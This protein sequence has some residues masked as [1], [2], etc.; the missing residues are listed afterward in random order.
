MLLFLAGPPEIQANLRDKQPWTVNP[1]RSLLGDAQVMAL[2]RILRM[3]YQKSPPIAVY[4]LVGG[5]RGKRITMDDTPAG[6][7][8]K[9][10]DVVWV[11]ADPKAQQPPSSRVAK[12]QQ[13][14]QPKSQPPPQLPPPAVPQSP[15]ITIP[16]R[17]LPP[18]ARPQIPIQY[19]PLPEPL[20][21]VPISLPTSLNLCPPP[22]ILLPAPQIDLQTGGLSG[23]VG[24][25]LMERIVRL[26]G[27]VKDLKRKERS[28]ADSTKMQLMM[29]EMAKLRI[30]VATNTLKQR[31][32]EQRSDNKPI[33]RKSSITSS[34]NMS[35]SASQVCPIHRTRSDASSS[36][37][38]C[39]RKGDWIEVWDATKNATYYANETTRESRWDPRG[40]P[41]EVKP[42]KQPSNSLPLAKSPSQV[43]SQSPV[44][45]GVPATLSVASTS[46]P[47]G[48]QSDM[49]DYASYNEPLPM[50]RVSSQIRTPGPQSEIIPLVPSPSI[51]STA[52]LDQPVPMTR[53][54]S[55]VPMSRTSITTSVP[56]T[57]SSIASVIVAAE[58]YIKPASR[59]S[60]R[61]SIA[62]ESFPVLPVQTPPRE[63]S[64]EPPVFEELKSVGEPKEDTPP[65]KAPPV[66]REYTE[67]VQQKMAP[68]VVVTA[69]RSQSPIR[70]M[71]SASISRASRSPVMAPMGSTVHIPVLQEV[72]IDTYTPRKGYQEGGFRPPVVENEL[73][74]DEDE[75][76][77]DIQS[78]RR[79]ATPPP[80]SPPSGP[81]TEVVKQLTENPHHLPIDVRQKVAQMSFHD[82]WF[83]EL[84]YQ[85]LRSYYYCETRELEQ[86]PT[87]QRDILLGKEQ[88]SSGFS[89]L[90][91]CDTTFGCD[92]PADE[93]DK[94]TTDLLQ[95]LGI[96]PAVLSVSGDYPNHKTGDYPGHKTSDYPG[97]KT[98]DYPGHK[99][100]DYPG[101]KTS[102]YPGHTTVVH[103]QQ[104]TPRIP[105]ERSPSANLSVL[106]SELCRGWNPNDLSEESSNFSDL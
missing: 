41:F 34:A 47:P 12:P 37:E 62:A 52:L 101:Q 43:P 1:K 51:Q 94:A 39:R 71:A 48:D 103:N 69:S 25:K 85:S 57:P 50:S 61:L 8:L 87:R 60:S 78:L 38:V 49:S 77:F 5:K 2:K 10:K 13:L 27:E 24:K 26:S 35:R 64:P 75:E 54:L 72:P 19:P 7:K 102:D 91:W 55:D 4:T 83:H 31:E 67:M 11:E 53:T 97:H 45:D 23:V 21:Q 63:K 28:G 86:S 9:S 100:S 17:D 98:S 33:E 40:T 96:D 46:V 29:E 84:V 14:Q 92:R 36:R 88:N 42:L 66:L 6:L 59:R 90:K 30:E 81:P 99:T 104:P 68:P 74:S 3:D 93:V 80:L 106:T 70:E 22:E 18:P 73:C 95:D 15:S 16:I 20:E 65:Q 105:T 56:P 79:L 32:S 76:F 82:P 44:I 58:D 89:G